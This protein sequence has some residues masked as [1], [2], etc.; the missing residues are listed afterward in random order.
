[1]EDIVV[2]RSINAHNNMICLSYHG[3]NDL[4]LRYISDVKVTMTRVK[5][6]QNVR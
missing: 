4:T 6:R 2:C 5:W 3:P 1:M